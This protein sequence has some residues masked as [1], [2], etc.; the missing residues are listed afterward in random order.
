[1]LNPNPQTWAFA[2]YEAPVL[3]ITMTPA[4][5]ITG[6]TFQLN[7]RK[8]D[9]TVV[10]Q[11]TSF[12]VIT[13]ETGIFKFQLTKAQTGVTIGVGDFDYDVWRTDSGSEKQLV[14]GR[15]SARKGR[16]LP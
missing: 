14:Y 2:A 4:E 7:I 11:S 6:Q 13:A 1:M 12:T 8:K 5:D 3:K 10:L 9:G 16:W 15:L